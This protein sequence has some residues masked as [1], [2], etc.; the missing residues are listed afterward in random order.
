[1][2]PL[3]VKLQSFCWEGEKRR[4]DH[5][6]HQSWLDSSPPPRNYCSS[7]VSCS[8]I[9][10]SDT[11][12]RCGHH[13]SCHTVLGTI[14]PFSMEKTRLELASSLERVKRENAVLRLMLDIG[15]CQTRFAQSLT[16]DRSRVVNVLFLTDW[17][18]R[19]SALPRRYRYLST[20]CTIVVNNPWSW[21]RSW[22]RWF[23]VLLQWIRSLDQ[24]NSLM[25]RY[26]AGI[27]AITVRKRP[28][29]ASAM[30][31]TVLT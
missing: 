8:F 18:E 28:V 2:N 24:C 22:N 13:A 27:R 16:G 30:I 1:M 6:I 19:I 31:P 21:I 3:V 7:P 26:W 20:A 29:V 14:Q 11:V 25:H 17:S 5:V 12:H 23:V 4:S 15:E 9:L 10:Q